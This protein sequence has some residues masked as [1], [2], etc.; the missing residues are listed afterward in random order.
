MGAT[1]RAEESCWGWGVGRRS[2]LFDSGAVLGQHGGVDSVD[3]LDEIAHGVGVHGAEQNGGRDLRRRGAG[4]EHENT[5]VASEVLC[6]FLLSL[7]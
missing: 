1:I 4:G 5:C 6:F 7:L 3:V 2:Y